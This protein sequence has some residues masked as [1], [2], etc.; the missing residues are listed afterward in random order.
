MYML[1]QHYFFKSLFH[2]S[3]YTISWI[4]YNLYQIYNISPFFIRH[5]KFLKALC[6]RILKF[7][8]KILLTLWRFDRSIYI[9]GRM[10]TT[11]SLDFVQDWSKT[12]YSD[13]WRHGVVV[14]TTAQLHLTEPEL[15]FCAG[16]NPA[17][18][19]SEIRANVDLWQWSRVEIRLNAFRLSTILQ[20]QFIIIVIFWT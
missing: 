13:L 7:K 9:T 19:V 6:A 1:F 5:N 15:R 18:G 4:H 8:I 10:I 3:S 11:W 2:K 17:R 12:Y 20:K 14:I 16:S